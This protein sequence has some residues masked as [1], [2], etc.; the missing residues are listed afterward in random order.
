M[1]KKMLLICLKQDIHKKKERE[2][3]KVQGKSGLAMFEAGIASMHFGNHISEHDK[4][5]AQKTAYVMCGGDLSQPS[6]VSER[7]LLELER[8]AVVSLCGEPKTLERMHGILFKR[9][10]IRN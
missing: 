9:K 5:I 2:D 3:I 7:Y 4:K 6:F 10:T 1:R 8:E